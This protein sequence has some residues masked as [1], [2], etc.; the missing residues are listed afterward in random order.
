MDRKDVRMIKGALSP[1]VSSYITEVKLK[2]LEGKEHPWS[3]KL[4]KGVKKI[5]NSWT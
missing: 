5:A 2:S 3:R 4:L 1:H